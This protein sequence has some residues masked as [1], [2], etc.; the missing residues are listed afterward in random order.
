MKKLVGKARTT[1]REL[2]PRITVSL[3]FTEQEEHALYDYALRERRT[4]PQAITLLVVEGTKRKE[5]S[6]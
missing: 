5:S 6:K 2:R 1:A 3:R 4:I